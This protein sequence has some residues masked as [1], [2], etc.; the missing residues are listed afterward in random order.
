VSA[1]LYSTATQLA[2]VAVPPLKLTWMLSLLA[3]AMLLA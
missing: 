3:G 1:P 2:V